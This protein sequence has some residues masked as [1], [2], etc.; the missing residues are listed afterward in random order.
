MREHVFRDKD[1]ITLAESALLLT[2]IIRESTKPLNNRD[3]KFRMKCQN[4]LKNR[5]G[6]PNEESLILLKGDFLE[7]IPDEF[8]TNRVAYQLFSTSNGNHIFIGPEKKMVNFKRP[9][10]WPLDT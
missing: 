6:L 2:A 5:Y 4:L 1:G 10:N 3:V 9:N 7:T 8:I